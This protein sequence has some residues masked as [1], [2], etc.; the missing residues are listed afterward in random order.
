MR[1]GRLVVDL[2]VNGQL[3]TWFVRSIMT[4][5]TK[6]HTDK[7]FDVAYHVIQPVKLVDRGV[8]NRSPLI[9]W[10][11]N[12]GGSLVASNGIEV[13]GVNATLREVNQRVRW[14]AV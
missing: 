8:E 5:L 3:E 13:R 10:T 7:F 1:S 11:I 6:P 4:A 2:L 9:N 12:D 14:D